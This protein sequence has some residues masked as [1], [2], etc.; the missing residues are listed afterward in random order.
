[1]SP[2]VSQLWL[3][4]ILLQVMVLDSIKQV[5]VQAPGLVP[6]G[7]QVILTCSYS[8]SPGEYIDS[9][10]WYLNSSEIYRIVPGLNRDRVLTFPPGG[11]SVSLPQSG[12]LKPGTHRLVINNASRESAGSYICQVTESRPPF[13][14]EQAAVKLHVLVRPPSSPS[15][16]G[17]SPS[18]QLG[19]LLNVSCRTQPGRAGF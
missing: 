4:L 18:Y 15:L 11:S 8:V 5:S 16:S 3:L 14:T 6:S 9:I 17:L 10:K 13:S 7:S 19:S 2:C 12:I 1:M